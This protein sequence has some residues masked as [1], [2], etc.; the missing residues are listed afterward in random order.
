LPSPRPDRPFLL[1]VAGPN[2]SGKS[3][4]YED[5]NIKEVGRSV[6]IINPDVLAKRIR[7]TEGKAP[8]DANLAAVK[9]IEA[10]L[11]ASIMA[12]Q[13]IGVETVLST[14]KYRKLVRLARR[15]GF[16]I[17]LLYVVLDTVERNIERVRIRV[18][19][20]GHGVPED[21]LR[22]RYVR[23]LRQLPWFLEQADEAWLFD[24][25]GAKPVMVGHKHGDVLQIDEN[26]LPVLLDAVRKIAE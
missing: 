23:S 24:N 12:Y 7:E 18:K 6:W 4:A 17:R 20:G 19:K 9:R 15:L 2:G 5:T 14:A 10:W 3:S 26:A 1:I 25:S 11:K 16:E 22:A 13:T 21:K 8:D